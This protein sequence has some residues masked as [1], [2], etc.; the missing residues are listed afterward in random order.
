MSLLP[1]ALQIGNEWGTVGRPEDDIVAAELDVVPRI[2]SMHGEGFRRG[3]TQRAYVAAVETYQLAIDGR[4]GIFEQ[5]QC[6]W[7]ITEL[8]ADLA[9][10]PFRVVFE[11]VQRLV[12]EQVVNRN[13]TLETCRYA[14]AID[15]GNGSIA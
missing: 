8:D 11:P 9:Q 4:A 12:V 2:A 14:D 7:I 3:L 15:G 5:I 6:D 10:Q 13:F 1:S